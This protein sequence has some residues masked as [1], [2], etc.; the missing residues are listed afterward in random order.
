MRTRNRHIILNPNLRRRNSRTLARQFQS[1][2]FVAFQA[3]EKTI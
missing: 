2:R 3:A 1:H